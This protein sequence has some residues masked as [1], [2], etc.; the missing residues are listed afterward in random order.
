VLTWRL[1]GTKFKR[2]YF[3][4]APS[5]RRTDGIESG[6]LPT[7]TKLMPIHKNRQIKDGRMINK[8]GDDYSINL[9]EMAHFGILTESKEETT[10]SK[11]SQLNPLFVAEMM[12]FPTDWTV[13]P[14]QNGENKV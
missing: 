10:T 12:G 3:Q 6:L 8:K 7:P 4:L 13:L 14:F 1:R 2:L 11:I 5:T 9:A